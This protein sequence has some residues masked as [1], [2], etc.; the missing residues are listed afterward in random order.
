MNQSS[1]I[2]SES[3]CNSLF[4]KTVRLRYVSSDLADGFLIAAAVLTFVACPFACFLNAMVML[5][6]KTKRRLQTHSNIVLACLALT[7]LIVGV[8]VQPLHGAMTIFLLQGKGFNEFCGINLAYSVSFV[9]VSSASLSHLVLISGERYLT[10]KYSFTHNEVITKPRI[11]VSSA[12]AWITAIIIFVFLSK[13]LFIPLAISQITSLCSVICLQVLVYKK[14]KDHEKQILAQQ[15]SVEAKARFKKE[16][17]ALKLTT[18]VILAIFLSF[19]LPS[20]FMSVTWSVFGEKFSDNVKTT[21]RHFSLAM[22]NL[23]S[24]INPIIYTVRIRH[25]RVAFIELLW[26]KRFQEAEEIERKPFRSRHNVV[27]PEVTQEGE[28]MEQNAEE[29]NQIQP[30]AGACHEGTAGG[31]K[32]SITTATATVHNDIKVVSSN[33]PVNNSHAHPSESEKDIQSIPRRMQSR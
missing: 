26:R 9:V 27:R 33:T 32:I 12:I 15:V 3:N 25:F 8:V 22:S 1:S 24:V 7:D 5:A 16:K 4:I 21:V 17:K 18:L 30:A 20:S 6:V 13:S 28:M 29:R 31:F 23:N 10:I 2:S 19:F 14:A 11:I